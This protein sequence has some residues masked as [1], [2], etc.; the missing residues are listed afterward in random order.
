VYANN[1]GQEVL[2]RALIGPGDELTDG[3]AGPGWKARR[4][5]K[6]QPAYLPAD[7]F[8]LVDPTNPRMPNPPLNTAV[9]GD[10]YSMPIL[11][12]PANPGGNVNAAS[13]YVAAAPYASQTEAAVDRATPM[14]NANDNIGRLPELHLRRLLGDKT[15]SPGDGG[16][17]VPPVDPAN[18]EAAAFTGPYLLWSAGPDE[19][20]GL[21]DPN[22]LPGP[23]NRS[24]D[25]A[26]FQRT[27]Y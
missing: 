16:I 3:H 25:V 15:P 11:Y 27:E 5:G 9:V 21:R 7:K 20:Y 2:T 19:T 13:G 23:G 1:K 12:Y 14:F 17:N 4:G 18:V 26:N 6:L 24:D 8:K 22:Q 10:R